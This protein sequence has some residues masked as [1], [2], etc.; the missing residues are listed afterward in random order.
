M[1]RL[2]PDFTAT[3]DIIVGFPGETEA[4]FKET[5][6]LVE[7]VQFAKVHMFPYS[8]RK[9]TRAAL[10]PNP[11][12]QDLIRTR[13]QT[14]L[15]LAEKTSFEL[16]QKFVGRTMSVLLENGDEGKPGFLSGHTP[17]FLRVWVPTGTYK[18]NQLIE[19]ELVGNEPE[20]LIG[21]TR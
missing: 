6:D 10:Y 1:V 19:V 21:R 17:N 20:G 8:P 4:D 18:A 16:R 11:V 14:L 15:R 2:Q 13:K 5:C 12:P 3:T 7:Q 9:R